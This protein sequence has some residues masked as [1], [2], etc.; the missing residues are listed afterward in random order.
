M[1][2]TQTRNNIDRLSRNSTVSQEEAINF[3]YDF[4]TEVKRETGKGIDSGASPNIEELLRRLPWLG[5]FV[6]NI[7]KRNVGDI[8]SEERQRRLE[9]LSAQIEA[10]DQK[11]EEA[12]ADYARMQE[13]QKDLTAR[14]AAFAEKEA[15]I[16]AL[17]EKIQRTENN[18]CQIEAVDIAG[19]EGQKTALNTRLEELLRK[20]SELS[21]EVKALE[22]ENQASERANAAK[23]EKLRCE[24]EALAEKQET[25][26]SMERE[27]QKLLDEAADLR[28]RC[29]SVLRMKEEKQRE[30]EELSRRIDQENLDCARLREDI[31]ILEKTLNGKDFEE[32]KE[33]LETQKEELRE[34]FSRFEAIGREI[35]LAKAKIE[36]QKADSLAKTQELSAKNN[37]LRKSIEDTS[38]EMEG[39]RQKRR[40]LE[41]RYAEKQE[42]LKKKRL[43]I[44]Q[45]S[46]ELLESLE[47]KRKELEGREAE[48]REKAEDEE[49]W[50]ESLDGI[51]CRERVQ[52]LEKRLSVIA[53]ARE[54]LEKDLS[55]DWVTNR[56]GFSAK[57]GIAG[58]KLQKRI[59]NLETELASVREALDAVCECISSGQLN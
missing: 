46:A 52:L 9:K 27:A 20:M 49:D 47:R 30:K 56:Y 12:N 33:L 8:A 1:D 44:E 28:V 18:I 37:E 42:N 2:F 6:L 45:A 29:E 39:L 25:A 55:A 58:D 15:Q 10:A 11:I 34:E 48:L 26:L 17:K 22:E 5:Q 43:E 40:E 32:Q 50:L 36:R 54:R 38:S 23:E 31:R 53:K 24:K 7:V 13:S 21:A 51:R 4:C 3:F 16:A 57:A 41:E 59:R 35:E 19:L 14:E